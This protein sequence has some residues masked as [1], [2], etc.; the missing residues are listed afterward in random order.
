MDISLLEEDFPHIH[1]AI[2]M[3]WGSRELNIYLEKLMLDTRDGARAGFPREVAR[4]IVKVQEAHEAE[5]PYLK[6]KN[7]GVDWQS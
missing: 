1:Q 5:F 3:C 7:F 2:T 4:L 6:D